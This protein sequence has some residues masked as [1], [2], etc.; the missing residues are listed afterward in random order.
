[1]NGRLGEYRRKIE[2]LTRAMQ[3]FCLD[4]Q[5]ATFDEIVSTSAIARNEGDDFRVWRIACEFKYGEKW[6]SE[7][8]EDFVALDKSLC[9]RVVAQPS[10]STATQLL[11]VYFATGEL[12]YIDLYYQTMGHEQLAAD[13]R[14]YLSGVYKETKNMYLETI[15]ELTKKDKEHFDKIGLPLGYVDFTYLDKAKERALKAKE[16][17]AE[18]NKILSSMTNN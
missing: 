1:M 16:D 8:S 3:T 4:P 2:R 18:A 10:K 17:V 13:T 15:A 6:G 7:P 11:H 5:K 12:K 14:R 9:D